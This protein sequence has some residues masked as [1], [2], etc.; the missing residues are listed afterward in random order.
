MRV[1]WGFKKV[2]LYRLNSL[3]QFA[4]SA[5]RVTSSERTHEKAKAKTKQEKFIFFNSQMTSS[6]Y[7]LLQFLFA[8]IFRFCFVVSYILMMTSNRYLI[9]RKIIFL[10]P[11]FFVSTSR[12]PCF[13][14]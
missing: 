13:Y 7:N 1:N 8:L 12:A 3:R 6:S 10:E 4:V 2:C 14:Y 5:L 9:Y 11:S